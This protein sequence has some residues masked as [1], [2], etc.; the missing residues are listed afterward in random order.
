MDIIANRSR[1][2]KALVKRQMMGKLKRVN[3]IVQLTSP[4]NVYVDKNYVIVHNSVLNDIY[5]TS[6]TVDKFSIV[7]LM[8]KNVNYSKKSDSNYVSLDSSTKHMIRKVYVTH[9]DEKI[10]DKVYVIAR[11]YTN[12]KDKNDRVDSCFGLLCSYDTS[13][14]KLSQ[15]TNESDNSDDSD[16][17]ETSDSLRQFD[18]ALIPSKSILRRRFLLNFDDLLYK[19]NIGIKTRDLIRN[20]VFIDTE[21]TNDIYDDFKT[22]P[23]SNDSSILFM[24]GMSYIKDNIVCYHNFTVNRLDRKDEKQ[25]LENFYKCYHRIV[26]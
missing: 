13:K 7:F 4:V 18:Y 22:F 5:K 19:M 3:R 16:I 1:V 21:F 14:L 12:I 24:I 8:Y 25:I 17:S 2:F 11:K 20:G 9:T 10:S 6:L 15:K 26:Y 23:V